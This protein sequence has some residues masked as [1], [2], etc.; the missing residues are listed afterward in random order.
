M[1]DLFQRTWPVE[2][3][4]GAVVIAHGLAEHSGRYE[5]VAA[6]L[7]AAGYA[8]YAQDFRGHGQSAGF[9]GDTGG[10]PQR[11][12]D[13][14]VAFCEGV[15]ASHP[16]TFLLAHSMG[17]LMALPAVAEAP[18]GTV[19]G[20]VLSGC[21]IMPG[22][23]VLESLATG[24]GIPPEAVSRDPAIVEAYKNDPLVFYDRVPPD[25][26]G[27]AIE[28]TQK[29]VA[30]IPLVAIPVLTLHGGGDTICD[31]LG[32]QE[33]DAQLVVTDKTMKI[34]DGLYHEILNEPERD[35]VI[36]DVIAWL[37]AH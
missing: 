18:A 20:L 2:G 26:M 30:A 8:A 19:D 34:Y 1:A 11:L 32:S 33:V 4:K 27:M 12:V 24:H 28:A 9:P 25:V 10:D 22:S 13:D 3:A 37:D 6:K 5:W 17:T 23:A 16:K 36:A 15:A 14:L 21:A 7:N 29:A 31:P 35:Q